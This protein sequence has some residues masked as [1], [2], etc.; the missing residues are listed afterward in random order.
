[1]LTIAVTAAGSGIG[2]PV[3]DSLREASL[4]VRLAGLEASPWGR[5]AYECDTAYL[6]PLANDL[7]YRARMIELCAE[8]HID[9]LIPGSD[10]ELIPIAE[11][12]S[13]L[14]AQGTV[15]IVGSAAS[16]R[17]CR[18]KLALSEHM[19][20]RGIPFVQTWSLDDARA[21]APHLPYPL[22]VKERSGSGSVGAQVLSAPQDW[23]RVH[24]EGA[25]IAQPYLLSASW[26]DGQRGLQ[27]YLERLQRTGRPVQQD[28]VSTQVL[29]SPRGEL[30]SHFISVNRLKDGVP[31]QVDPIDDGEVWPDVQRLVDALIELGLRGPCN[32]QGRRTPEGMR[33]F[34]VNP[35]FT[36]I[37]HVRALMGYNEVEAAVRLFALGED[38]LDA[39]RCL[40]RRTDYVGLRQMSE[41]VVP[42][43]RLE[44]LARERHL[45]DA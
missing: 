18:D 41:I 26:Y 23:D 11:M 39:C 27:P 42:R 20:E 3:I 29:V 45:S 13:E 43:E 9:L 21:Q 28:E 22:I 10:P 12:A 25:W 40:A 14:A 24:C 6:F 35:R 7:T 31:M 30:V 44:R 36:G 4:E 37:T 1:M 32:V 5:G 16:I 33:F 19:I 2:Q 15:S 34:E 38:P 17:L 8:A